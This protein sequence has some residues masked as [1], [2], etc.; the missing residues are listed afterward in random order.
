MYKKSWLRE[1]ALTT[2]L[3]SFSMYPE[4]LEGASSKQKKKQ[5]NEKI[6]NEHIQTVAAYTDS[7]TMQTV[8]GS[9]GTVNPPHNQL[10]TGFFFNIDPLYLKATEDDLNYVTKASTSVDLPHEPPPNFFNEIFNHAETLDPHFSW[11][12][13]GRL[14]IG[15][16]FKD[17]D[18]WDLYTQWTYVH[19]E[20]KNSTA[21]DL[22]AIIN[23]FNTGSFSEIDFLYPTWGGGE[24]DNNYGG[25]FLDDAA[26]LG[27]S[28]A[29]V[30]WMMN[31]N[32]A[33][34]ELG[35]SFYIGRKVSLRPHIGLRGANI[36]QDYIAN[37]TTI[38]YLGDVDDFNITNNALVT[39]SGKMNAKND[40]WG[41]GVRGG[42]DFLWH[43]TH[44][45]GVSGL[46]SGALLYSAF[47]VKQHYQSFVVD[48][49]PTGTIAFLAPS[50][51][52]TKRS[53]RRIRTNLEGSVG[54]FW[55]ANFNNNKNHFLIGVF[56]EL[57][58]WFDQNEMMRTFI[59]LSFKDAVFNLEDG[60][61]ITT[62]LDD[63]RRDFGNLCLSG[64][65]L[66]MRFD[67]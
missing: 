49:D 61:P 20:A 45:W 10:D 23:V 14:G 52:I 56:Y 16:L 24:G 44:N 1:I 19:N 7:L 9:L 31:L 62:F 40:F 64:G 38:Y 59:D 6:T 26:G 29:S 13:G 11:N 8:E 32:V 5:E 3:L 27:L 63:S 22:N 12:W 54:M 60:I 48:V 25:F 21:I 36:A 41:V 17:F 46:V 47:H 30:E 35:R 65:S 37:Y 15:Y 42:F 33:D 18:A 43:F 58:A 4:N 39:G 50:N 51:F 2:T 53:P 66:K 28:Q 55:E 57:A 67:F 34:L